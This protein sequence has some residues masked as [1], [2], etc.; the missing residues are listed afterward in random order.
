MEE[1]ELNGKKY[2]DKSA[3]KARP[4]LSIANKKHVLVRTYSAGVWVGYLKKREGREVTLIGARR[5]WKWSGALDCSEIAMKG[6]GEPENCVFC[7]VTDEVLLLEA[8]E[9]FPTTAEARKKID[10]VKEVTFNE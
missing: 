6:V 8:I 10:S 4:A 1:I 3:I 7:G 2:I 5:L 9:I